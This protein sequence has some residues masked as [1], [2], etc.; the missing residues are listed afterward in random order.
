MKKD[1]KKHD[2]CEPTTALTAPTF[3]GSNSAFIVNTISDSQTAPPSTKRSHKD[4]L[5]TASMAGMLSFAMMQP[6]PSLAQQGGNGGAG[7]AGG[8][9]G[10]GVNGG[11][12]GNGGSGSSGVNGGARGIVGA[13]GNGGAGGVGGTNRGGR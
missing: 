13:G 6:Y 1:I 12:G 10:M 7:R 9:G 4:H 5:L 8:N 3:I 2:D 11:N